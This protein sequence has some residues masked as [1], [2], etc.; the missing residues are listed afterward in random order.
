MNSDDVK[1]IALQYLEEGRLESDFIEYKKSH[2]QKDSILKTI[3]AFSNNLMNRN[4]CMILVGV[5]EHGEPDLKGTPVRPICGYDES[6]IETVE[7][8]LKSLVSFIKPKISYTMT[9]ARL[10]GRYF[11]IFAFSNNNIGPYEV[12]EKAEKDKSVNLKRGRYVRVER[13]SRLATIKEEFELLKKF[14][15]YH[16]TEEYSNVASMD[17]LDVDYIREYLNAST[18]RE[19]TKSLSKQEM[20][21][22]TG[23]VDMQTGRVKNFALLMF[24]RNPEKFIPYSYVELIHKSSSGESV[25]SSKEF[26]GPIWKQLRNVMDDINNSYLKSLTLRV[27]DDLRSETVYN[28]P[29]SAIEELLTNAIVHKNYENPRTVQVYVYEDS[30]VITNYNKPIPPITIHD[31]NTKESFPNRMYENPSI[32]EMFRSLDLIESFGSG[33]GKAKRA[34][35]QNGSASIHYEEYDE[36]IDITSVVIPIN[37]RYLEYSDK[38][39]DGVQKFQVSEKS[40]LNPERLN[41]DIGDEN[42]DNERLNLDIGDVNLDDED[43]KSDFEVPKDI[44]QNEVDVLGI[45][46][47]SDYSNTIQKALLDIYDLYFNTVFGRNNIVSSLRVSNAAGTNYIKYLLDIHVIEPVRGKGKGRYRF[48]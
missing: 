28:Y 33:V 48:R 47:R 24:S 18:D 10:D 8:S 7:N 21:E 30:M 27:K 12:L 13:D 2:L 11:V 20:A 41:L 42:L 37:R 15:D 19:N 17:D 9:H 34:M 14:S 35:V 1:K 39:M 43:K 26:R 22:H 5:E 31:L 3:C 46:K 45:I 38:A 36:N 32:R 40:H 16:F 44:K 4:L 23:L 29:Y 6:Q 25:M